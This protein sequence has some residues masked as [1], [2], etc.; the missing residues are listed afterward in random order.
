[1]NRLLIS[2]CA[3]MALSGIAALITWGVVGSPDRSVSCLEEALAEH[4]LCLETIRE[5]PSETVL[6]VD[7][8]KRESWEKGG[9]KGSV[10]LNEHEDWGDMVAEFAAAVFGDGEGKERVVV[11]CDKAGC[12]SS[13]VVA[14]RLREEMS[15]D[16]GFE[17]FVLHGG[18]KALEQEG[19]GK[20]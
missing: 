3:L 18:I 11:Y 13:K 15:R 10:L 1:M 12:D 2:V 8:R 5:W 19:K 14:D 4:H 6:W 16:F 20:R 17:V 7:A 9:V